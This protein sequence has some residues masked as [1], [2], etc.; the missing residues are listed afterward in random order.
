MGTTSSTIK[1]VNDTSTDIV[2]TSVYDFDSFD[3]VK[4]NDPSSNL[5]GLSINAKRSVE[6]IVDLFSPAS[7]C[8]VTVTLTFKDKS[9]D[10]FRID[11]KYA[12]GCCA[13]FDHSRRSHKMSHTL[14]NKKIIVTIEN[15]A[16]QN[17]NEEA[18]ESLRRARQAMRRRLYDQALDH[19]CHA[20]NLA[21]KADIV[22]E[23]RSEESEVY[24]SY[25]DSMFEEGLFMERT[26]RFQSAEGKFSSA[27]SFFQ[28][29]LKLVY[30]GETQEKIRFSELKISGNKSTNTA[31][32]LE[33]DASVMVENEEYETALDKYEAAL[34]KYKEAKRKQKYEY[35]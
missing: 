7:H 26:E 1:I 12:E 24:S 22:R 31:K 29:S 27:K 33:N 4:S 8:P 30:S 5:N 35:S 19:L 34:R 11:L 6:R 9:E 14:D 20:K 21:S 15:T 2:N 32:E 28:R 23:I 25:G 16:E 13:R 3:F 10:T 18:E 17:K